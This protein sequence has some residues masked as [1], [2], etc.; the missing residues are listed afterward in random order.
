ME[1][2]LVLSADRWELTDERTGE[3]R[4]GVT[5]SYVNSYRETTERSVGLRPTKAPA[6]EEAFDAIRK[7]GA[8]GLY[9]LDFRTRPGKES[10]PVVTIVKAECIRKLDLFADSP[11]AVPERKPR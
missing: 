4:R 11:T 7:A 6:T 5:L 2:V 1:S 9:Q 10:V 8:P 3:I